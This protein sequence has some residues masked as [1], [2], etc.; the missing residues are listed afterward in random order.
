MAAQLTTEE[1]DGTGAIENKPVKVPPPVSGKPS[2]AKVEERRPSQ[3][4]TVPPEEEFM[5]EPYQ[6]ELQQTTQQ[7]EE[8]G[9]PSWAPKH[10]IHKVETIYPYTQNRE[11]E[12]T[13][14]EG[15]VIY[16]IRM[17][18]DGWWEG[19]MEGG[20]TGLFPGNYAE[21]LGSSV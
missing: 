20:V 5:K 17:N 9:E 21:V 18:D 1:A 6:E 15:T 16:V 8:T 4:F 12:L 13:F 3:P 7:S 19:V 2:K 14:N 10:F 11:D